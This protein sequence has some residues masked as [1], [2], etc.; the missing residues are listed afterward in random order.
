[1]ISHR[2]LPLICAL[3]AFIGQAE[4]EQILLQ[5]ATATFSQQNG[6]S[7]PGFMIGQAIDGIFS[8]AETHN[9]GEGWAIGE[10]TSS[11]EVTR[12]QTAAFETF[13]DV[14]FAGGTDLTFSLFGGGSYGFGGTHH[15]GR[16]RLSATTADRDT[17]A[18]GL[19]TGGNIGGDWTVLIPLAATSD[20]AATSFSI[21]GDGSVLATGDTKGAMETY[22]ISITTN[23]VG[24]TGFRL[25]VLGD[26]SLPTD[27]PG[28]ASNGNFVLREFTVDATAAVPEPGSLALMS[29]G[30][31]GLLSWALKKRKS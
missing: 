19:P 20:N 17:F 7:L 5:N 2:T 3:F 29:C 16:F 30:A 9:G 24:I 23:L 18:N 22:T 1:M 21:L 25:E 15:I 12:P 10:V 27:G 28:R 6:S 8:T 13:V 14:G 4:A 31:L 11:G 26:P